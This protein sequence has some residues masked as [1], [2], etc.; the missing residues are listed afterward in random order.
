MEYLA[1]SD[2][3]VAEFDKELK[4]KE[5]R[6]WERRQGYGKRRHPNEIAN[7]AKASRNRA[8]KRRRKSR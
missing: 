7:R 4:M 6:E 5:L 3:Y 2:L 1:K 8:A